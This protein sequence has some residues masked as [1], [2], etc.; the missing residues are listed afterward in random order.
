VPKD[1][2]VTVIFISDGADANLNTLEQRM[3]SL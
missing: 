1:N 2:C 3:A